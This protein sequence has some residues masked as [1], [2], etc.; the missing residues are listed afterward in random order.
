MTGVDIAKHRL[1]ACRTML[2]KYDLGDY[3]RLFVADGTRFSLLPVR[4]HSDSLLQNE[5]ADEFASGDKSEVYGEWKSR[6][7]WKERKKE[8]IAREKGVSKLFSPTQEPELIF[9]GRHSGVVGM[10][11]NELYQKMPISEVLQLGYDKNVPMMVLLSMFRNLN[12]GAGQPS[13]AAC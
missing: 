6:R 1:A 2:Q 11:K 5:N 13:S 12:N 8:A 4:V 10:R 9:Y 3:C 7:P